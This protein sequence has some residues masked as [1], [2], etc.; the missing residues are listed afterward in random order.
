MTFLLYLALIGI[1]S[2]LTIRILAPEWNKPV[3][4]KPKIRKTLEPKR[5]T[6]GK[7]L[8]L[9]QP[10]SKLSLEVQSI[11]DYIERIENERAEALR[12]FEEVFTLIDVPQLQ[13]SFN[14]YRKTKENVI[15]ELTD[16]C[17]KFE[18]LL[19][20][21]AKE[22]KRSDIDRGNELRHRE[23]FQKVRELLETQLVELKEKNKAFQLEN[24]ELKKQNEALKDQFSTKAIF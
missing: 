23:E 4:P 8:S 6:T 1:G 21:R 20:E 14:T 2:Y 11:K 5:T 19:D 10:H 18:Q 7:F 22:L 3:P 16:K 12:N 15:A 9:G 24:A 13:N 17:R